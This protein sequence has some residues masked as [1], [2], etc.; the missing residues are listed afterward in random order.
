MAHLKIH[1]ED[2]SKSTLLKETRSLGGDG[3][4][5]TLI[6]W[7]LSKT[8]AERLKILQQNV[9]SILRLRRAKN[10]A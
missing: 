2:P 9:R 7:M 6:R 3:V 1:R 4:D 8:P 10:K 5:V